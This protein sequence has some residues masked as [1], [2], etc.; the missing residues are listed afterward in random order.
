MHSSR[1]AVRSHGHFGL[2]IGQLLQRPAKIVAISPSSRHLARVMVRELGPE[3][4]SVIELGSGTGMIT[5]AILARGVAEERLAL[6]EINA[7]FADLLARAY[8]RAK[9]M[10]MSAARCEEA[11][12]EDVG[13][14]VSGLPLLSMP[15]ALQLAIVGGAFRKM[16]PG[17]IFVQFTYGYRPPVDRSVREALGLS[18]T[19]SGKVWRNLPPARVYTFRQTLAPSQALHRAA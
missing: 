2:F 13:A 15:K 5:E 19:R 10:R 12:L 9:L 7:A 16:R 3:T 14:V 4:G 18:W 6:F 8:P 1:T 11:P 17:G